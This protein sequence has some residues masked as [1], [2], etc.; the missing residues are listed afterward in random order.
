MS[1]TGAAQGS[2]ATSAP[3]VGSGR[4]KRAGGAPPPS[5]AEDGDGVGDGDG[6]GDGGGGGGG[7]GAISCAISC[8]SMAAVKEKVEAAVA[9]TSAARM[10]YQLVARSLGKYQASKYQL[11]SSE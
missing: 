10:A 11:V 1:R 8:A 4:Q 6:D 5:R 7:G 9:R 2:N 3:A